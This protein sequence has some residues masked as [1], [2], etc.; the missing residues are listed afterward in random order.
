MPSGLKYSRSVQSLAC[1]LG[2][3]LSADPVGAILRLCDSKI[4]EIMSGMPDCDSLD[5]ML[6]W[7]ANK[8]KTVF[9]IVETDEDIQRIKEKYFE[10]RE[11]GFLNLEEFLADENDLGITIRLINSEEWEPRFVS[12]ID[13][14]GSK[15]CRAYFTK[16]H[17]IA[18]I[19]TMP[20]NQPAFS[21]SHAKASS[22]KPVEKLMDLIA[23]RTG[24]YAAISC[25]HIEEEISFEAI[26]T[27]RQKLCPQASR[28]SALINFTKFW[29]SP[30]ILVCAR[31]AYK[32]DEEAEL[33]QGS[34]FFHDKPQPELRAVHVSM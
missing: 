26:E 8:V 19:L 32:K 18:H 11:V 1:E 28:Q 13:C 15:G 33:K 3:R 17:E 14:R 22:G 25:R 6:D 31:I 9:E 7:V 16:W 5:T 12:V 2:F 29:S 20:N 30:C 10:K 34:F 21:F 27:L 23:G 4:K 24:F